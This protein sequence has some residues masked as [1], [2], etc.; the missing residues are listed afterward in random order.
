MYTLSIKRGLFW[1]YN[2]I[3]YAFAKNRLDV[4]L[5]DGTSLLFLDMERLNY[6]I[7]FA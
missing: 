2:H 5:L 4:I 7:T 1:L 3:M 6:P